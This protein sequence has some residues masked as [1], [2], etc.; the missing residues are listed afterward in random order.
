MFAQPFLPELE[1]KS[2]HNLF[3]AFQPDWAAANQA[4]AIAAGA[5]LRNGLL[6]EGLGRSN[7]HVS[8]QGVGRF[9]DAVP[10]QVV[11]KA[12]TAASMLREAPV[13]LRFELAGS[14]PRPQST[15]PFVLHSK[16]Q[17]LG[18]VA[19]HR[20]LGE[21]MK[22]QGLKR[23]VSRTLTP[24]MTL[25]YDDLA[26]RAAEIEPVAW[27]AREFVLIHSLVGL[28]RHEVLG[29]WPLRGPGR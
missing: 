22:G 11:A 25:L 21:A 26:L 12:K 20:A 3:F 23:G 9:Y 29:R 4:L 27:T 17:Q 5:R 10:S 18:V 7:L 6:S 28:G 14:Y 24:H 2:E 15:S 8:L 16:V 19:F 1:P 13:A